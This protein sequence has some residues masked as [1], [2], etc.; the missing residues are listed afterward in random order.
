MNGILEFWE[1]PVLAEYM[2]AGW[3]QWADAGAVSSGLPRYLIQQVQAR[4]IGEI[5]PNGFY[6]FQVPGTH[7]LLRPAVK[8]NEGYRESFQQRRNEFFYAG[9]DGRGLVL[10][11]GEEPHQ[12]EAQYAKAFFDAVEQLGI[13]RVAAV[14]GVYGPVPYDKDRDVSCAYSLPEMKEELSQY[15]IRFSDYEGGATIST[16]LADQAEPRGIEFFTF[17]AFVPSYDFSNLSSKIQIAVQAVAI[18]EDFK[19]WYDLMRRLTHMF[20]LELDLSDLK[21]RSAELSVAWDTKI[22]HVEGT[23]PEL[24][25]RDYMDKVHEDFHEEQFE[26]LSDVWEEALRDLFNDDDL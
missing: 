24:G 15:A 18:G 19:A 6:L 8:L 13:K 26:P 12:N 17:Y 4:K 10:F 21:R 22:A 23:M 1:R 2:I 16:Y 20:N 25:V 7:D 9:D 5:K 11:L 3:H 14:A